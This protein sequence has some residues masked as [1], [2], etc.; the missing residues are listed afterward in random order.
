[1]FHFDVSVVAA[2]EQYAVSKADLPVGKI[3]RRGYTHRRNGCGP[4]ADRPCAVCG[5]ATKNVPWSARKKNAKTNKL[6]CPR[7]KVE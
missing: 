4:N 2:I 5:S 6:K 3:G 1:M 7:K